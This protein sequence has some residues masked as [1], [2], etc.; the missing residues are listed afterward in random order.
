MY[1]GTFGHEIWKVPVKMAQKQAGAAEN[2]IY[3][4]YAPLAKS[5]NEAWGM[6]TMQNSN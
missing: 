1:V 5:N 2:L 6:A 3:G 4:H